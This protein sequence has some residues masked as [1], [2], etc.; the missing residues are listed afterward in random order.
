MEQ[1]Y[2]SCITWFLNNTLWFKGIIYKSCKFSGEKLSDFKGPSSDH[3]KHNKI[4]TSKFGLGDI[5]ILSWIR[6]IKCHIVS[7]RFS[8][9]KQDYHFKT[10]YVH[11]FSVCSNVFVNSLDIVIFVIF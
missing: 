6:D 9:P 4:P 8:I 3:I 10:I 5:M 11:D 2:R 7:K 1:G